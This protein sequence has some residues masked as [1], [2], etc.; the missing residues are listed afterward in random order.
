MQGNRTTILIFCFLFTVSLA[1]ISM[2]FDRK[3]EVESELR[4]LRGEKQRMAYVLDMM[5]QRLVSNVDALCILNELDVSHESYQRRAEMILRLSAMDP[6]VLYRGF[7]QDPEKVDD[8]L[9]RY[10]VRLID[11]NNLEFGGDEMPDANPRRIVLPE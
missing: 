6:L 9:S 11:L 1:V 7:A 2:I 4:K 8:V 5:A 10:E 3:S